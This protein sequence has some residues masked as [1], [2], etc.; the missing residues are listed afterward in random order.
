M[1]NIASHQIPQGSHTFN[2][3]LT[4]SIPG[5][6]GALYHDSGV[7]DTWE[8][9]LVNPEG[10][11]TVVTSGITFTDPDSPVIFFPIASGILDKAG[12]Y[13]FQ[14]VKTTTGS[15]VKSL[16]SQFEVEES[17]PSLSY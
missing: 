2:L 14:V 15:R 4:F 5:Y 11:K 10:V 9:I 3:G 6:V 12:T 7:P 13:N 8:V 1:T 16:V 17:E